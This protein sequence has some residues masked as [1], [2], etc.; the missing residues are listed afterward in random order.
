M[1]KPWPAD[2]VERRSVDELIGFA[3]NS[4]EHS[5]AQ[6][7]QI[8]ASIR[9]WGWTSPVLID[10]DG[11]IL[12]GHGR[13]LAAKKLGLAEVPTMMAVGWTDAQKRAYVIAD[14]KLALNASWNDEMLAVELS[15]LDEE[16]FNLD[17]IGFDKDE[18]DGLLDV[19]GD[20]GDESVSGDVEGKGNLASK[21]GI[22][23][24]TVL[25]AREGWW[26]E[27]KRMW[28]ALGIKSELGRGAPCLP[29]DAQDGGSGFLIDKM[30]R[31]ARKSKKDDLGG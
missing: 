22:P 21:F 31:D 26:Q 15:A 17:L 19:T 20:E 28:I 6:V 2:K 24:F 12:A 23:P 16:G 25:S 5:D 27:R 30:R 1:S 11:T 10:E 8:A 7:D 3:R 18:L 14:N 29:A 13:L 9:E 4:R